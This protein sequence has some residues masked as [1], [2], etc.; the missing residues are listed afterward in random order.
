M[1]QYAEMILPLRLSL[2]KIGILQIEVFE[3]SLIGKDVGATS[4]FPVDAE[5]PTI[6]LEKYIKD[7]GG[8]TAEEMQDL[9]SVRKTFVVS[10]ISAL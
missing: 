9:L 4:Y 7:I 3:A 6:F 8:V 5:C 10:K 2:R 1:E